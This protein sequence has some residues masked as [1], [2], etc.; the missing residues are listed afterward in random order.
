LKA[1]Q[2][3]GLERLYR[4]RVPVQQVITPEL[5]KVCAELSHEIRRQIGLIITRRGVIDRVIVGSGHSLD[6][7]EVGQSRLG[8]RSLR[9]VRLVHTHLHDEPLN[10]EDL[11]DLALLRL[12]LIAAVGVS[13]TGT[14][15]HLY[16]AHLVPPNEGGRVC[17][18]FPPSS[19]HNQELGCEQFIEELEAELARLTRSHAVNGGQ[20]GAI[21][22]SASTR[23]RQE[24]EERLSELSELAHSAGLRVLAQVCQRVA[25][26]NAKYLLG[27][28]KLKEVVIMALQRGADLLVFDQDLTPAQVRAI[29]DLTEMKILDRTQVILDIFARRAH[30]REGKLQVELAQLQYLLPRLAGGGTAMSRLG[31]GI[32]GRGPG[33]TKLETDRRRVRDRISHLEREL[34]A[35]VQHR[36]QRRARRIREMIPTISIVGYTNAGKSTLLNALTHSH[37]PAEDRPFET[38]DTASR[39]LRF[40]ED[41]EV[42]ITDTVGFIRDLPK[43]L[44]GAFRATLEELRDADVLLHLVDASSPDPD[45]EIQAVETMLS[46]LE[47]TRIPRV[48]VLNKCDRLAPEQ[49]GALTRRYQALGISAL[50]PASLVPLVD[51]LQRTVNGCTSPRRQS[52]AADRGGFVGPY[53]VSPAHRWS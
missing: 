42:I 39:R 16:V 20:E 17:E 34:A 4:R 29:T 27:S 51:L 1:G 21:L 32:G 36:D 11:T 48:M 7:T 31:G 38:L 44:M 18:V 12:D 43:P 8:Q 41:R 10:Q 28:G 45:R 14:P 25:E 46:E 5:A 23:S 13:E 24:Q 22:V 47:L 2:L 40:P 30:S 6:L 3:A 49:V 52:P 50:S 35:F 19:I 26:I 15:S 37:V 33:E 53:A 9:G